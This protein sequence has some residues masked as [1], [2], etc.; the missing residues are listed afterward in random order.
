MK[1]LLTYL[2]VLIV[3]VGCGGVSTTANEETKQ[4]PKI[5]TVLAQV[6]LDSS[7][8]VLNGEVTD[9]TRY[10]AI[11]LLDTSIK[12]DWESAVA[13]NTRGKLFEVLRDYNKAFKDY[14]SAINLNTKY[15]HAYANRGKLKML[16]E[17]NVPP[18]SGCEDIKMAESLGYEYSGIEMCND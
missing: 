6:Y 11:Q 17:S 1:K 9:S 2:I 15:G 14:D 3:A 10:V 7:I 4:E 13:Y 12:L 16:T 5:D 18:T 8:A